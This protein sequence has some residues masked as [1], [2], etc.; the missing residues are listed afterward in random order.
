MTTWVLERPRD[1]L[2]ITSGADG[3]VNIDP[4]GGVVGSQR[5]LLNFEEGPQGDRGHGVGRQAGR[6]DAGD[7]GGR[8][9]F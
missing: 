6:G 3:Y 9:K 2:A 7:C 4:M 8:R 1:G 5:G